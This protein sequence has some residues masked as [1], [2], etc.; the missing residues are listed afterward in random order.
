MTKR[1]RCLRGKR[2]QAV[3]LRSCLW[4][5]S[6][7]NV[8]ARGRLAIGAAIIEE[9][10]MRVGLRNAMRVGLTALCLSVW[11]SPL[12]AQA[13]K[14]GDKEVQLHGSFQQGFAISGTNNFLTMNTDAGS[15]EMT[16]VAFNAS[17]E[18]TRKLRVGGQMYIRKIGELGDGR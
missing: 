2:A 15:G 18:L 7:F 14:L 16:D 4:S 10:T 11:A 13:I 6:A 12:F 1:D 3:D 17:S 8:S 9:M 5:G